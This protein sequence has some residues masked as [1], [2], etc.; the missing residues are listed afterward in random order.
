MDLRL[1]RRWCSAGG[2]SAVAVLA[3][4]IALSAQ[5]T[6]TVSGVVQ[7]DDCAITLDTVVTIG[8]L[9]GPGLHVIARGNTVAVDRLGRILVAHYRYPEISVFDSTGTFLRTIGRAGEGPGEFQLIEHLDAGPEYIHVFDSRGRTLFDYDFRVVRTDRSFA[10]N[11]GDSFVTDDDDVVLTGDVRTI[12][13]VGHSLHILG[14]SGEVISVGGDDRAFLGRRREQRAPV[15]GDVRSAWVVHQYPNRLTHWDLAGKKPRATTVI[16]RA[17]EEF[18]KHDQ[19]LSPTSM[20]YG[21]MLDAHGL[22]ILWSAP[23]P[24]WKPVKDPTGQPSVPREQRLDSWLDLVDP[25]TGRTLSR[26]RDD[27][28]LSRFANGSRYLLLYRET[29]A[30]IP[31]L[32]LLNP[33]LS[34]G[35]T[36]PH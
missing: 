17:V 8:G 26:Y 35:V 36:R 18:D 6:L 19:E 29:A 3:T 23:D 27:Y 10:G 21:V 14:K 20:N 31:S 12:A 22:W 15:R 25:L 5:D 16:D 4:A 9:D 33:T 32:T 7:C 1:C 11:L 28:V 30:G 2:A 13:S 24:R 34:R